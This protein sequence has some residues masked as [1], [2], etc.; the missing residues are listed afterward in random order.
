MS[1]LV[2]GTVGI[3]TVITPQGRA[4][5]VLGGSA[6]YF[7]FAAAL[8]G[9]VRLVAVVGDDFPPAFRDVLASADIDLAGLET[10]TGSKTFRWTGQYAADMNQRDTLDLQLNV[11]SETP[12]GV[13]AEFADSAVV[14]LANTH[15]SLQQE[16]LEQVKSPRLAVCDTMDCWIE[17][18]GAELRKTLAAVDG[19]IIND[20]EAVQ[21]TGQTNLITAG[22]ALLDLGPTFAVIKKGAH[23]AM[24][25]T[26][27][28]VTTI[29]AFP[30]ADVRDPT[31]AGDSFAGGMLG[32]LD[33]CGQN[34]TAALRR[35]LVRGTVAA[36][37]TI[38]DYSLNRLR[39]VTSA[40]VDRRVEQ[41]VD[42]LRIE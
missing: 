8:F 13:P 21:L 1:L 3:D 10:R 31:G 11:V 25:V 7:S 34:D 39:T 9:R 6:T 4:P 17:N 33:G 22:R 29:P 2:T 23:G 32:Y 38:E 19:V 30:T 35:A 16:L 24:L 18:E 36:S 42:M 40:D 41:F 14:F 5:D 37:F 28:S 27:D 26:A 12:P 20:G 15:P